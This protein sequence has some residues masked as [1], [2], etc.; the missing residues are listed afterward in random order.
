MHEGL[1][2][3]A[4]FI[5]FAYSEHIDIR[6]IPGLYAAAKGMALAAFAATQKR[7]KLGLSGHQVPPN[8]QA[9][10]LRYGE[11]Q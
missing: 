10:L 6:R 3:F 9:L 1:D 2:Q 7:P 8:N 11:N 5:H 4:R